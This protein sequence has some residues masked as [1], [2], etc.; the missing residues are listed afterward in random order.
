[1]KPTVSPN[2]ARLAALAATA[3][4]VAATVGGMSNWSDASLKRDIAPLRCA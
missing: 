4:G 3:A 1:M 2:I